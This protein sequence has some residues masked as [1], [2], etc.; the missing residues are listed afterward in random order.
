MSLSNLFAMTT[1][2]ALLLGAVG[3]TTLRAD[4]ARPLPDGDIPVAVDE[5]D[6]GAGNGAET[7]GEETPI[8]VK[9]RP[10]YQQQAPVT[11]PK[12][13]KRYAAQQQKPTGPGV[14]YPPKTG[15]QAI[16]FLDK[17]GKPVLKT[18][19][20]DKPY[21]PTVS[22]YKP[23]KPRPAQQQGPAKGKVNTRPAYQQQ[24]GQQY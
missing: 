16:I 24:G 18:D 6:G 23:G 14:T 7:A 8:K 21:G 2:G 17:S 20:P 11:P 12:P 19:G 22:E 10:A 3:Y 5:D 1:A 9:A 13:G 15:K 4:N